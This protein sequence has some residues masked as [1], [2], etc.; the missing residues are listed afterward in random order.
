VSWPLK[1]EHNAAAIVGSDAH[2]APKTRSRAEAGGKK[3]H[4]Y[5]PLPTEFR[6][7]GFSYRQIAREGDFAIYSQSWGGCHDPSVCFEVVRIRR[8][9]GFQIAGRYVGPAELYPA[10]ATW[11]TDGFTIT[12]RDAAFAKLREICR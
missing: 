6:R 12:D 11:G 10:S 9:D 3:G 5:K 4:S 1:L 8:R 2:C 7:D